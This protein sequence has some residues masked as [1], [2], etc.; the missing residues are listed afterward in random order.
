MYRAINDVDLSMVQGNDCGQDF[1]SLRAGE[2]FSVELAGRSGHEYNVVVTSH[3]EYDRPDWGSF[4]KAIR[5]GDI[6]DLEWPSRRPG[7]ED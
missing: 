2:D 7:E 5:Q 4:N 1:V 6:I 3:G